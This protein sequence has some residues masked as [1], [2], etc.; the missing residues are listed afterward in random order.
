MLS[1]PRKGTSLRLLHIQ[2]NLLND[3]DW[4]SLQ[5]AVLKHVLNQSSL[6]SMDQNGLIFGV[7]SVVLTHSPDTVEGSASV[8][9]A[10]RFCKH[11]P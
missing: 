3:F 10:Q 7:A 1:T 4:Y 6:I 8:K 2:V 11:K 9:N 5:C